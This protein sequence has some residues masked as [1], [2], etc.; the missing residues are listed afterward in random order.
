MDIYYCTIS[1]GE[2]YLSVEV[3]GGGGHEAVLPGVPPPDRRVARPVV[4]LHHLHLLAATHRDDEVRIL[5][6]TTDLVISDPDLPSPEVGAATNQDLGP[7]Q[8]GDDGLGPV[9]PGGGHLADVAAVV[10]LILQHRQVVLKMNCKINCKYSTHHILH[11]MEKY[12]IYHESSVTI[13]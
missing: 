10:V 9:T 7:T 11:L 5:M 8:A 4:Q 3:Q 1:A 12:S 6:V 13:L 2:I